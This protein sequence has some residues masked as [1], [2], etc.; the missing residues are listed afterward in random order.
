MVDVPL[1]EVPLVGY[2]DSV[3]YGDSVGS[4][5][6]VG[7]EV[8]VGYE[9]SVGYGDTDPEGVPEGSTEEVPLTGYVG[10]VGG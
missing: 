3:G 7:Y 5:D 9:G 4:E 1:V 2:E 10:Y 8:S 6:S